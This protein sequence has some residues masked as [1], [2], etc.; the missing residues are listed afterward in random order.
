MPSSMKAM[1]RPDEAATPAFRA[2]GML[3]LG[4]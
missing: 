4:S 2:C 3:V 1:N